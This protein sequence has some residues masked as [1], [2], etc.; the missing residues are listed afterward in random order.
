[1]RH[2]ITGPSSSGLS[3]ETIHIFL[4]DRLTKVS[5]IRVGCIVNL[6]WFNG[7][8]TT[9]TKVERDNKFCFISLMD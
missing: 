5:E 9:V 7:I 1:M 4:A 8:K 2:L 3:D 6:N